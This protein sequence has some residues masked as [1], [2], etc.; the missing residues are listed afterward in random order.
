MAKEAGIHA[1]TGSAL[2]AIAPA[3]GGMSSPGDHSRRV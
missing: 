1:L 2:D 3:A